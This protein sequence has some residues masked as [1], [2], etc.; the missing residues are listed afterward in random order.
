ME[1]W[2][3]AKNGQAENR[4]AANGQADNGKPRLKEPEGGRGQRT[5]MLAGVHG[6]DPF[7]VILV[8]AE[9][10]VEQLVAQVG[11][12]LVHTHGRLFMP[13]WE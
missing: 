5:N 4:Q 3:Q 12:V 9:V 13:D 1:N 2:G 7:A 10:G 11:V 6:L 8:I